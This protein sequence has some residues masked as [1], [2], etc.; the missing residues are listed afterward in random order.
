MGKNLIILRG[1]PGAGKSTFASII[2]HAICSADD[3][4]IKD[5]KYNWLEYKLGIAHNWCIRKCSLFM[6]RK[7]SPVIVANTFIKSKDLK[8]YIK[9]AETY[10]YK[11]F[12]IIVENRHCN[13]NIHGVPTEHIEKLKKS[14]NINL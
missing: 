7:I 14:F 12:S 2:G 8:P 9:L 1:L 4:F 13:K 10:G 5:G 11:V 6:K 3:Y